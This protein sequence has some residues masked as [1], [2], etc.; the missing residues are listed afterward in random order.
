VSE[1]MLELEGLVSATE[2]FAPTDAFTDEVMDTILLEAKLADLAAATSDLEPG[3]VFGESLLASLPIEPDVERT[4]DSARRD[5]DDLRPATGL[6][7][8][9]VRRIGGRGAVLEFA[10]VGRYVL[11]AAAVAAA[12]IGF[13]AREQIAFDRDLASTVLSDGE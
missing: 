9:V 4:L 13:A 8:A 1:G 11:V 12:S 6:V 5:T 10:R 7:D 2:N 3:A